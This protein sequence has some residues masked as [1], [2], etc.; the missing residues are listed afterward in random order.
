MLEPVDTS[1]FRVALP[2]CW[3]IS[4]PVPVGAS[5]GRFFLFVDKLPLPHHPPPHSAL[6][7][8]RIRL[9]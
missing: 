2:F 7:H 3:S 6:L 5:H 1:Q 9:A 4:R 8:V